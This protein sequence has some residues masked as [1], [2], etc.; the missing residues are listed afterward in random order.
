MQ[1]SNVEEDFN[2]HLWSLNN[3]WCSFCVLVNA[4]SRGENICFQIEHR[5]LLHFFLYR[6]NTSTNKGGKNIF[7]IVMSCPTLIM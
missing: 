1:S 7:P 5:C 3:G 6:T 2:Q 4:Y